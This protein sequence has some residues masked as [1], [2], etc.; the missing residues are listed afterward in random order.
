MAENT[1][2]PQ[3]LAGAD[4]PNDTQRDVWHKSLAGE[5]TS[6]YR[7]V[8]VLEYIDTHLSDHLDLRA[9]SREAGISQFHFAALFRKAVGRSPHQHILHLRLQAARSMLCR[10]DKSAFEIALT[11]GFKSS[12]HFSAAFRR[13][14]SQ[15]P[16]EFRS[17]QQSHNRSDKS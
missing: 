1:E 5:R 7:L 11:C 3:A 17:S 15:S 9:L 14:F 13:K 6:D 2:N 4:P 10:K 16:T 12:S 8:R